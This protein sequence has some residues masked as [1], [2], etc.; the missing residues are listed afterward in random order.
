MLDARLNGSFS[1]LTA[2][3]S[4][5]NV[6]GG[7]SDY[8]R[9]KNK[10]QINDVTLEG[11]KTSSELGLQDEIT[12]EN[13][14][15][16]SLIANTPSIPTATSDLTNDGDG[17]SP[18]ATEAYVGQNGGK[19]DKIYLNTVEQTITDKKV[20][21]TV[22]KSTVGLS[23]VDNTSDANKPVS[24]AQQNA[25]NAVAN[26]IGNGQITITQGGTT[27]G[28]FTVNQS[29]N[30][31]IELDAGGSGGTTDYSDLTN[32]PQINSVTLSGNKTSSE[33]GL[34]AEITS[35]NKLDYSLLTNTPTIPSQAS[36]V[37]ALPDSTKYGASLGVSGTSVQ[38]KDQDGNNLGDAITT[39]DTGA[40]SVEVAGSGNAV[41]EASYSAANRKMTLTKGATY[42]TASDVGTLI[43][44][45]QDAA[46]N[47]S[48]TTTDKTIVGAINEVNSLAKGRAYTKEYDTI[49]DMVTA[50]NAM[51]ATELKAGDNVYIVATGVPDL[52][53]G[54]V[55]SSAT[56]YTYTTDD[57]FVNAIT[58]SLLTTVQVGYYRLCELETEKVDLSNVVDS[59]STIS[60]SGSGN[61]VTGMSIDSSGNVT[62]TKGI[63]A[64]ETTRTIAGV[65]LQDNITK[66]ELQNALDF[67]TKLDK[68]TTGA[69]V[70]LYG[71]NSSNEQTIYYLDTNANA[72]TVARRTGSGAVKTVTPTADEDSANKLY[73]DTKVT[74]LTG[75]TAPTTSTT[76]DFV[77]QQYI[78]TSTN[79]VYECIDK[80]TVDDVTTYAWKELTNN[81]ESISAGSQA[82]TPDA[83]GNVNIPVAANNV[84]GTIRQLSQD[85]SGIGFYQGGIFLQGASDSGIANRS[86][87]YGAGFGGITPANLNKSV[88]AALTD[89]NHLTM[90]ESEQE[91]AQSVLG[92][93]PVQYGLMRWDE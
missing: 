58:G 48:L 68:V 30:M 60:S 31:T 87:Q 1:N 51:S 11:N 34:Q 50:L 43:S 16:Y 59:N 35:S 36:D 90:T 14:L 65:D 24:T 28:T 82:L 91:T 80:T 21:L 77:G 39:Q 54:K 84:Y 25:I 2:E 49:S 61:A 76:A 55:E 8:S 46:N 45:K 70:R 57:D 29:G 88:K 17:Q 79:K 74:A 33:L 66:S 73:V 83:N 52:W 93:E 67:D 27:K 78:D 56:T 75:N 10:P 32:K 4:S 41:T 89:A 64:V 6:G 81:I 9:L 42:T 5:A 38:L 47:T 26:S 62:L 20:Y 12:S 72:N 92:I 18:F 13:K 85:I 23:N 22:D 86:S 3:L 7:T 44:G 63:T 15:D 71:V 53:V 19:I 69:G 37:H 40:T